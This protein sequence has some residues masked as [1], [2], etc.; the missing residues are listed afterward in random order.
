MDGV[1]KWAW[2]G[3]PDAVREAFAE[4]AAVGDNRWVNGGRGV[5]K[6][7]DGVDK[8]EGAGG[9]AERGVMRGLCTALSTVLHGVI[10]RLDGSGGAS[11]GVRP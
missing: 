1:D 2:G 4:G 6:R 11:W 8:R 7:V 3:V 5:Q 9:R 10:H